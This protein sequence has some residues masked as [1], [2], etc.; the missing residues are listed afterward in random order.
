M[1]LRDRTAGDEGRDCDPVGL[2]RQGGVKPWAIGEWLGFA[3]WGGTLVYAGAFFVE[4]YGVSVGLTGLIL[5]AGAAAY[6]PGDFAG[7][8]WLQR[9]PAAPLVVFAVGGAAV[10]A[11]FAVVDA[12]TVF[13]SVA[14]GVL[15]FPA[16]GGTIA[17]AALGLRVARVRRPAAMSIRTSMLQ[18]GY[19]AGSVIG[20]VALS[21]WGFAGMGWVFAALFAAAA[22]APV[23]VGGIPLRDRAVAGLLRRR[24]EPV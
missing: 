20:G 11:V 8:R 21:W 17:G 15:A 4:T 18:F 1:A 2:W 13:S 19:L 24:M 16:A 5:G 12:G 9:G 14:F 22:V 10:V 6:L 7:R 23:F 3:A